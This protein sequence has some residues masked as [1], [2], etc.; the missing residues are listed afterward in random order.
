MIFP[1]EAH[2]EAKPEPGFALIAHDVT[3][4]GFMISAE[5]PEYEPYDIPCEHSHTEIL[6][7]YLQN[8]GYAG[9]KKRRRCLSSEIE[10]LRAPERP[11][12]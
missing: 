2:F 1:T 8:V 4:D 12:E 9:K 6:K 10:K 3:G 5:H 7:M 11:E